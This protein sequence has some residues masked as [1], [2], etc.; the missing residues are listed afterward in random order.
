VKRAAIAVTETLA[1][2]PTAAAATA[3]ATAGAGSDLRALRRRLTGC[4]A[5]ET[6]LADFLEDDLREAQ[7]SLASLTGWVDSVHGALRDRAAS[8]HDLLALALAEGP[9]DDLEYLHA[10]VLS[11]RRRLAQIAVRLPAPPSSP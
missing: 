9:L 6:V 10:T 3:A 4:T 11:L 7:G 2:A 8:R 5:Q 1:R